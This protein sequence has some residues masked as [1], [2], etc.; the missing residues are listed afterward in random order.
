MS[1]PQ[2]PKTVAEHGE[3]VKA[4]KLGYVID[5]TSADLSETRLVA[6]LPIPFETELDELLHDIISPAQS[7]TSYSPNMSP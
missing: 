5:A 6:R 7:S 3:H 2:R 4:F 1:M